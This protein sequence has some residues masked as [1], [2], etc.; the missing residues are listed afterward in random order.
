[1]A[2]L[3]ELQMKLDDKSFDP[4]KL[5]KEQEAA[6]DIAFETGQLK[7]Y[8]NVAEIRKEKKI[9]SALIAQEKTEKAQPFTTAT[10]PL[11]PSG[12]GFE[13]RDLELAGDV[14]AG[15]ATYLKEA[16]KVASALTR[17]EF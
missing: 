7:G 15:F 9:G 3:Q 17:G 6:V 13:R 2:T 1:M 8:K 10:K 5:T 14:T 12:E 11:T 4:S 16:P